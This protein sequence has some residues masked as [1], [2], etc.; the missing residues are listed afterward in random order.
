VAAVSSDD[1]WV[2]GTATGQI[3]TTL[4]K[5]WDGSRW[6]QVRTPNSDGSQGDQLL[7]VNAVSAHDVWAVGNTEGSWG[8][9]GLIEHWNG[10]RWKIVPSPNREG[11]GV[12]LLGVSA[13]SSKDVWATGFASKGS[14]YSTRFEHWNGKRWAVVPGADP[15]GAGE[16]NLEG[17]SADAPD[18]VWASGFFTDADGYHP[19]VEHWDGETW[20]I[21][22]IV[23][24]IGAT[25]TWLPSVTAISADDVWAFGATSPDGTSSTSLAEHWNGS[26]WRVV[27]SPNPSGQLVVLLG[28]T[29][30][31]GHDVWAVGTAQTASS[32]LSVTEHWNGKRWKIAPSGDLDG[33]GYLTSASAV[34][35]DDVWTAG[36]GGDL[37]ALRPLTEHWDG[38]HWTIQ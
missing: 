14:T 12:N 5:H 6:R 9:Y 30:V 37:S 7:A 17:I 13:V 33:T 10:S 2:V 24:P 8:L 4:A 1:A 3:N 36:S 29:A 23:E 26:R 19:L 38:R 28:S 22:D 27:P 35:S 16:I 15:A 21:T 25:L 11:V 18:D 31:S 32:V 20:S 34:G